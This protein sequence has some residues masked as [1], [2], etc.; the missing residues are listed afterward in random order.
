M[1]KL[2]TLALIFSLTAC[3]SE[4][5]S[6]G[7]NKSTYTSCSITSSE[8]ILASDRAEDVSQCW[9]GVD[10]KE[11]SL[12]RDWCA[13]KVNS[14]IGK[15]LF[16]PAIE[17]Q[18][19]S[20][21]CPPNSNS[22]PINPAPVVTAPISPEPNESTPPAEYTPPDEYTRKTYTASITAVVT[23]T[24]KSGSAW[25]AFGG[26]PDIKAELF[27]SDNLFSFTKT[28]DSFDYNK[29]LEGITLNNNDIITI[30]I[31]DL[32][33]SNHDIIATFVFNYNE[34]LSSYSFDS[35]TVSGRINFIIE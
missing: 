29:S 15:Y 6:D 13:K 9:D 1:K 11:E 33:V 27:T 8:A 28:Q 34:N 35:D 20:T 32:D 7:S 23:S 3:G 10:F 5:N 2:T 14:Y 24:K 17:Y 22:V 26:S 25:D 12:A 31:W 4:S 21:N 18:I 16:G 19:G 30:K